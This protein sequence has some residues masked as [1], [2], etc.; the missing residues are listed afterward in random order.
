C[1]GSQTT[2][3]SGSFRPDLT[4]TAA[5]R[6]Q[7]ALERIVMDIATTAEPLT[8]VVRRRVKPGKESEFEA[9][10]HEFI[11]FALS[12]PGHLDVHVLR[13]P[14]SEPRDYTVVDRF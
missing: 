3:R 11:G 14:A 12:F 7:R 10:M 9:A 8:V 1:T 6:I 5:T 4:A 13:P 2:S